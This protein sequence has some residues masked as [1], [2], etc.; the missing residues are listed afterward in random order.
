MAATAAEARCVDILCLDSAPMEDQHALPDF[1]P[2]SHPWNR[3][4]QK[5]QSC[6][7][8]QSSG[9]RG[10]VAR[11]R[12]LTVKHVPD[13]DL[14]RAFDLDYSHRFAVERILDQFV[15]V[16]GDLDTS[17]ASMRFHATRKID[18]AAQIITTLDC[19]NPPRL[20]VTSQGRMRMRSSW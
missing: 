18:S 16:A 13:L 17:R 7:S 14:A 10:K 6:C 11:T 1:E 20:S 9:V 4:P 5:Q 19:F 12:F 3:A 8:T 2:L 15:G